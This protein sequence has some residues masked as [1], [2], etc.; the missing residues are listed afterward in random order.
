M[1]KII[2]K[3]PY[4]DNPEK[5]EKLKIAGLE[6]IDSQIERYGVGIDKKELTRQ[7]GRLWDIAES[8]W[9]FPEAEDYMI[10]INKVYKQN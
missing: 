2:D 5:I 7:F 1:R 10:L 3:Q 8:Y 4:L 9:V 6:A